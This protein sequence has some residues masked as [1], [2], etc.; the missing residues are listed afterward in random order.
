MSNRRAAPDHSPV[1]QKIRIWI[2]RALAVAFVAF[3]VLTQP[4]GADDG[5]W[6]RFLEVFGTALIMAGVIGR[7]IA[8]LYIGDRKNSNLVTEGP[9]SIT[10]NPLYLCSL[11][12]IFGAGLIFGSLI[13]AVIF[14]F[15]AYLIFWNTAK[16]EEEYLAHIFGVSFAEYARSTPFFWPDFSNMN[17]GSDRT[18]SPKALLITARDAILIIGVIPLS[19]IVNFLH[20]QDYVV[21]LVSLP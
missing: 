2:L 20:G 17:W 8:I 15:L 14:T 6:Q 13:G 4:F 16:R 10:R 19:E 7:I 5:P 18:F 3:N 1:R 21:A 11:V 9:Y 12:M